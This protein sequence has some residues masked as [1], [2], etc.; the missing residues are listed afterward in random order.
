M[1][2]EGKP[3]AWRLASR[4]LGYLRSYKLIFLVFFVGM[5]LL[6][7]ADRGR[8]ALI[9]PLLDEFSI[10]DAHATCEQCGT[11]SSA[12]TLRY[13]SFCGDSFSDKEKAPPGWDHLYTLAWYALGISV[14]LF[15][16]KYMKEYLS[17]YLVQRAIND[18]RNEVTGHVLQLPLSRIQGQKSGD[19]LSRV[20]TDV[21]QLTNAMTF[22]CS[23]IFLKPFMILGAM[24]LLLWASPLLGGI[25]IALLPLTLF[26]VYRL[27][28]KMRTSSRK[29]LDKM[30]EA[31]ESQVQFYSGIRIVKAYNREEYE[32]EGYRKLNQ[33]Y[34]RKMMSSRRRRALAQS[35][36]EV[37]IS[38][39]IAA[40]ILLGGFL[41]LKEQITVGGMALFALAFAMI[42][43]PMKQLTRS[44][45]VFQESLAGAERIFHLLD[46]PIEAPDPPDAVP[47]RGL[48]EGI[49]YRDV[50]FAYETQPVLSGVSF[51]ARPGEVI[52]IVGS[53]GAGK[54]TLIDLLCRFYRPQR[55]TIRIGEVDLDRFERKSLL[56][57]IAMVSQ[58]P[59]LF[60]DTIGENIRYGKLTA[61]KEEI[62][63]AA[64]AANIQDFIDEQPQGY[65][66][67]VGD[68][69]SKL[70]GGQRQR[71][72]IARAILKNPAI[73]LLDEA[74][75]ALDTES[76]QVV[77]GALEDLMVRGKA[78]RITFVIAHRMSTVQNADRILLLEGGRIIESGT[79]QELMEQD[80]EYAR[81][82]RKQFTS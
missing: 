63:A 3:P 30:G 37:G 49:E 4:L 18:L 58:E 14:L 68:R 5:F 57:H 66:T 54:S 19:L 62:E 39:M 77:Q 75:S 69:G 73:L 32:M 20:T 59:F 17:F 35:I 36:T 53:S 70:S 50:T 9:K 46:M 61:T 43:Q 47:W 26:P 60:N 51:H 55:G 38:I 28:K 15:P 27:G 12:E 56:D 82:Y 45:A 23:D 21:V 16:L 25:T 31:T 2:E 22:L 6:A 67:V 42:N 40:I 11:S 80:R 48:G 1:T 64:Q 7:G 10:Q 81:L 74:T 8:A 24:G 71:M 41:F 34:F 78:G 33:G 65:E 79:H 13:C 72:T 76:E 29:A 44:Y 52:A